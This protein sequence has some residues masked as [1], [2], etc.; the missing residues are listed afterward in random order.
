MSKNII[1]FILV[2]FLFQIFLCDVNEENRKRMKSLY[3]ENKEITGDYDKDLS[4]SCNNG[5]F[6]GTKKED[7]ISFKG[8]PYAKPPTGELRWKDPILVE[9]DSKVYEAYYFGK[10]PIQTERENH[11]G[12][13]YPKSEDCLY[14]NV[15]V[16]SKDTSTDKPIMV[17]I[18]GGSYRRDA[19][20]TPLYDGHNLVE[21]YSDLILVTV[22]YRLGI[23]GFMNFSSFEGGENYKTSSILGLLDQICAL[24]WIQKNIKNFGGDPEKVIW[25]ISWR[26]I[27]FLI[28]FNRWN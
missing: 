9:D 22:G 19:T 5:I 3:G 12:S 10:S 6:V 2:L 21:K 25:T 17:F 15:W 14:L 11:L 1:I 26:S 16:N 23:Y 27:N 20:S 18:H 24:K 8:I 28:T 7:V 4:V 13:Y